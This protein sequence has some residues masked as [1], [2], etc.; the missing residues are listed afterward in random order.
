MPVI[1]G[2]GD[3]PI[4]VTS[5]SDEVQATIGHVATVYMVRGQLLLPSR[6]FAELLKV[7]IVLLVL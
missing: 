7:V 1:P 2:D 3:M 6:Q 4:A 5:V